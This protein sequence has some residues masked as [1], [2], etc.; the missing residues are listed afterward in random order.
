MDQENRVYLNIWVTCSS[1]PPHLYMVKIGTFLAQNQQTNGL[2][3]NFSLI[4]IGRDVFSKSHLKSW[5]SRESN[6]QPLDWYSS[7]NGLGTCNI[8]LVYSILG[9]YIGACYWVL[10][11]MYY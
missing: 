1:W 7:T 3:F 5:K 4:H 9:V 8:V 10:K 6:M 2:R 11:Y